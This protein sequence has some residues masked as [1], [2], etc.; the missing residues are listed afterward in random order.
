MI[1]EPVKDRVEIPLPVNQAEDLDDAAG[2]AMEDHVR[3]GDGE[4]PQSSGD[5]AQIPAQL[6]KI[7]ELLRKMENGIDQV[8]GR[9]R[10]F[11]VDV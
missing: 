2:Y 11:R 3:F 10:V 1:L 7:R 4:T 9:L 8:I 5:I 6:G